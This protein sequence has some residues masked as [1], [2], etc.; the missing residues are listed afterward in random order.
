MPSYLPENYRIEQIVHG[1]S[2]G[3]HGLRIYFVPDDF[4]AT[5]ETTE[6]DII[7]GNGITY[8]VFTFSD[9]ENFDEVSD[10]PYSSSLGLTIVDQTND[11]YGVMNLNNGLPGFWINA[12]FDDYQVSI[13]N[14]GPLT[15]TDGI[16]MVN[17]IQEVIFPIEE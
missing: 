2:E 9:P 11:Y 17:S 8:Y 15:K 16:N 14:S 6:S 3:K 4:I 1:L 7:E 10:F 12:V 5:S 13:R